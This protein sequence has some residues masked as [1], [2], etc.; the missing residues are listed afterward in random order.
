MSIKV[1]A[2]RVP[3]L[4]CWPLSTWRPCRPQ[5]ARVS[6]SSLPSGQRPSVWL[7]S[8]WRLGSG[9]RLL[10][11]GRSILH[12]RCP[13]PSTGPGFAP[14]L[15]MCP[16]CHPGKASRRMFSS[17]RPGWEVELGTFRELGWWVSKSHSRSRRGQCGV[18]GMETEPWPRPY[19]LSGLGRWCSIFM[20]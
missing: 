1:W 15:L 10:S 12:W 17:W 14:A 2:S 11:M 7:P 8:L 13:V 6:S 19:H 3:V 9:P 5:S 18:Q 20:L 4:L 16:A